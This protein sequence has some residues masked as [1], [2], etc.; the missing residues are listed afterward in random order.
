M[1]NDTLQR[2]IDQ[3]YTNA[4]EIAELAGVSSSTVYRW[5]AGQSQPDF[6]SIRLL[7]RLLPHQRAQRALIDAFLGGS[8]WTATATEFDLDVNHD[9][10]V[11]ADDALDASVTAM[12]TSSDALQTVRAASRGRHL[13]SEE[14]L[15]LI[16]L[17]NQTIRHCTVTQRV[18]ID[19]SERRKKAHDRKAGS[20]KIAE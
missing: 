12:K 16:A 7:V 10:R 19:M 2:I 5:I 9:G 1:L 18:L 4:K 15:E 14:T 20:L 17:L 13:D 11:D 8:N 3:E 6:D